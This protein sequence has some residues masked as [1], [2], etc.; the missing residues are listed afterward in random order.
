MFAAGQDRAVLLQFQRRSA[1]RFHLDRFQNG[2][3]G[4]D[5][6]RRLESP[7]VSLHGEADTETDVGA[8]LAFRI[9]VTRRRAVAIIGPATAAQHTQ[10]TLVRPLRITHVFLWIMSTP[11]L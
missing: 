9:P 10:C 1:L 4:R 6:G 11:I 2:P 7:A 8:S 5:G 3:G